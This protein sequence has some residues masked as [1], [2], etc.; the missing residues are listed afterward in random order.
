VNTFEEDK[1]RNVL[2]M[3][4]VSIILTSSAAMADSL[5]G[6]LGI[7]GKGGAFVPLKND[8][9]GATSKTETG[10]A[11]GGGLIFGFCRNFAAE[12][13]VTHA[14]NL[15][16]QVAGAKAFDATLTDIAIGAQYRFS[17]GQIV[18]YLGAGADF[19]QGT[20]KSVTGTSYDLDWTEGGHINAGVDW[21]LNDGIALTA[22]VRG[23]Y[24]AKGD[25]KS[26]G[27]K[28]ADYYPRGAIATL[29]LRLV[30]PKSSAW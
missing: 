2:V 21:F 18:P 7:T 11:A 6:R 1:M 16:V 10:L 22:E 8:F 25:V 19:I 9:I 20:L 5:D 15:D 4:L 23:F 28:V 30:L 3:S 27:T 14:L 29:G 26:A 17:R 13:D 12:I 24:A